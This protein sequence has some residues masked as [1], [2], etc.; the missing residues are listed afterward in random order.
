M[1][2]GL[3]PVVPRVITSSSFSLL[4]PGP[5]KLLGHSQA[6]QLSPLLTWPLC[7]LDS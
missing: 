3:G 4:T 2:S 7:P 5:S 6:P 1:T